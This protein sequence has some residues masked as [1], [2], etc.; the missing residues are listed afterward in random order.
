MFV[1]FFHKI[2]PNNIPKQKRKKLDK[3]ATRGR[4]VG[5]DEDG[6]RI[7]ITDGNQNTLVRSRNV[8]F[9]EK[10][11][12]IDENGN[13]PSVEENTRGY[14]LNIPLE[15]ASGNEEPVSYLER[16][17]DHPIINEPEGEVVEPEPDSIIS[18]PELEVEPERGRYFQI[19][20][21]QLMKKKKLS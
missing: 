13:S 16:H 20:S 19:Q 15:S 5:Y 8:T 14:I 1:M 21:L 4:L 18:E 9:E 2:N 6:Y 17:Q 3:K 7:W 12:P 10:P 11:L